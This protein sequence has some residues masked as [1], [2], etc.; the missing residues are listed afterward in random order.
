METGNV[1]NYL[2]LTTKFKKVYKKGLWAF[3]ICWK[4]KE[5]N[6]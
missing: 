3:F 6:T 5:N 4:G 2:V 1:S